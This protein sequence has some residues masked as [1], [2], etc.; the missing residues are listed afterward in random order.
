[1]PKTKRARLT[2]QKKR[3]ISLCV[4]QTPTPDGE[5]DFYRIL[6]NY[7]NQ[8]KDAIRFTFGD[9]KPTVASLR[10]CLDFEFGMKEGTSCFTTASLDGRVLK[11]EEE[12]EE[13]VRYLLS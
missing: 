5:L 1:M 4:P 11:E 2:I 13:H 6:Y 3:R 12:M 10:C 9:Q 8:K 7:K